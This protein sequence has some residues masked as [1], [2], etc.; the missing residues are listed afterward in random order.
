MGFVFENIYYEN[1]DIFQRDVTI[2]PVFFG[3]TR[4]IFIE[5]LLSKEDILPTVYLILF[6]LFIE[7]PTLKA[8]KTKMTDSLWLGVKFEQF[9][10]Y[11]FLLSGNYFRKFNFCR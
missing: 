1:P 11:R 2:L 6:H 4:N 9:Y 3:L 5:Y 10:L 8:T 7:L